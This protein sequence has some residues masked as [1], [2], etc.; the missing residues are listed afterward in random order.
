MTTHVS[1][2]DRDAELDRLCAE[3]L[4]AAEAG[5]PPDRAGWL[6]AHPHLAADLADFLDCLDTVSG[7]AAPLRAVAGSGETVT[8]DFGPPPAPTA[9]RPHPRPSMLPD[10]F[11]LLVIKP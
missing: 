4:E 8:A 7:R 6:A 2:P 11:T 5:S 10:S 9:D 3:Y 1:G